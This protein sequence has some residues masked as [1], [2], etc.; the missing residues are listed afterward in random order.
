MALTKEDIELIRQVIVDTV[1]PMFEFQTEEL[2]GHIDKLEVRMDSL[3]VRMDSLEARMDSLEARMESLEHR[4]DSLETRVGKLEKSFEN[5]RY[6]VDQRFRALEEKLDDQTLT[7][8]DHLEN[9]RED[10]DLLFA[11]VR[12]YEHGTPQQKEFMKLTVERQVPILYRSLET[13]AKKAG[14]SLPMPAK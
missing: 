1:A 11:L 4:I 5:F 8:K 6:E 13:V 14:V 7:I 10:I 3:E 12:K 2:G 9:I